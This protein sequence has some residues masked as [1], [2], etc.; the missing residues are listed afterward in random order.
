MCLIWGTYGILVVSTFKFKPA[1][2]VCICG[3]LTDTSLTPFVSLH[4][5]V[6]EFYPWVQ[7]V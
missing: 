7:E 1:T 6:V 5:T 3:L 2:R 4:I